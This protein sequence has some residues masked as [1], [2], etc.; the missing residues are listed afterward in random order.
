MVYP[1]S[2]PFQIFFQPSEG[3]VN[4]DSKG[5]LITKDSLMLVIASWLCDSFR[6]ATK[7]EHLSL[8]MVVRQWHKHAIHGT[9]DALSSS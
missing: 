8:F 4:K 7:H 5:G 3:I 9:D 1:A 6:D 2:F